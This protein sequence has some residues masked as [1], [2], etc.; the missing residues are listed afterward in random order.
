MGKL[1]DFELWLEFYLGCVTSYRFLES[2]AVCKKVHWNANLL[3]YTKSNYELVALFDTKGT[4]FYEIEGKFN[5]EVGSDLVTGC[6]SATLL[7][8]PNI[9]LELPDGT[10]LKIKGGAFSNVHSKLT[11]YISNRKTLLND[12]VVR[13]IEKLDLS[14]KRYV[15]EIE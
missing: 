8:S 10:P 15:K 13:A 9:S 6:V 1:A 11:R 12:L 3:D 14:A 5:F 2:F 7:S 4:D